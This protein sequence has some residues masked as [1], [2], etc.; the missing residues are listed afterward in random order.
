MQHSSLNMKHLL[1][2]SFLLPVFVQAQEPPLD[3]KMAVP[4]VELGKDGKLVYNT[5][6]TRQ[7]IP[8]FSVCGYMGADEPIPDVPVKIWVSATEGDETARIQK[9]IDYVASLPA[10]DKGLRGTVLLGKGVYRIDGSLEIKNSG[11]VLR[12][13][14]MKDDETVLLGTGI[15]RETLI[16]VNAEKGLSQVGIENINLRSTYDETN[17]KDEAHRWMAITLHQAKDG[18][19]RRVTFKH[20]AGSAVAVMDGCSRITVEDC[21]SLEPVSEIGGQRRNTFYTIGK[22]VLFQRLYAENGY[23]DFAVGYTTEGPNAFV[24]CESKMP[25]SY[26]GP[27]EKT[28][29][30]VLYDLVS[31]EGGA[32]GFDYRSLDPRGEGAGV[33]NSVLWQCSASKVYC[34]EPKGQSNWAAG[35]WASF[36]GNGHWSLSNTHIKPRSLYYAQL[37]ERIGEAATARASLRYHFDKSTTSPT[38]E[39]AA[40]LIQE[41][42]Q[43]QLT[44]AQLID[45]ATAQNPIN[46]QTAGIK[47]IDEIASNTKPAETA[48]PHYISVKNGWLTKDGAVVTGGDHRIKYWSG[49]TSPIEA[50]KAVPHITRYVPGRIGTGFTDDLNAVADWMV[51]NDIE[52]LA[53]NY[54][55]WYDRRRDD[56]ERIRRMDGDVRAPF[57]ELP[58]ARSGQGLGW[59]GLSKYD[60]TKYNYWYWNR[61]QQFA[62]IADQKGLILLHQNYFQHNILEAGAHYVDYPWR[63][64]NN[65]NGT[66]FPEPVIFAEDKRLFLAEQYYNV[67]HDEKY[68]KLH[69]A[70]IEKCLDNFK[71][72]HNVIQSISAEY[73]GPLG[74]MQFWLQRVRDWEQ[75]NKQSQIISLAA[76]KNVQD[77]ILNDPQYAPLVNVIDIEYWYYQ[78]DGSAYAPEG[79]K[80]LSPRQW[81]RQLRPKKTSFAQVYRAVREYRDKYPDKA[82]ICTAD[83]CETKAWAIFMAGGS[84]AE[85]PASIDKDF[86]KAAASMK[87]TDSLENYVLEGKNGIIVYNTKNKAIHLDLSKRKANFKARYINADDG[88]VLPKQTKVRGGKVVDIALPPDASVLWLSEN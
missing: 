80:N 87:P 60:L 7:R 48:A 25:F 18:W 3:P 29:S 27:I 61:L 73:T 64:T 77:A 79:G 5:T 21:L 26:S 46:I 81:A 24:Q 28:A 14:G 6:A 31:I 22:Q 50:S 10:N 56:H 8:D 72:N 45:K 44:M 76:A 17:P 41:A 38:V 82:I 33:T 68:R 85:L 58:F 15:D 78:A 86:L 36:E 37:A 35:T 57:Y 2:L 74:F 49:G 39:L 9:A 4:P 11:I 62:N 55:L 42:Y 70:Y 19:V 1:I 12:G 51:K 20:F 88:A 23:H 69:E 59:D 13:S 65:V 53:H 43:P 75:K 34:F 66:P 71:N 47:N 54:G 52:V 83:S 84:L 32:L 63:P 40:R 67:N 30:K 16:K